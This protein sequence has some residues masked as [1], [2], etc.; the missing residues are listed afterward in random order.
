MSLY[1]K[2]QKEA[3][4]ILVRE[5]GLKNKLETPKVIKVVVNVGVSKDK[6]DQVFERVSKELA[7]VT[8]QKPRVCQAKVSVAGFSLRKGDPIGLS[9]TLRG[10][11]MYDFLE[12]LFVIVLPQVKDFRGLPIKSFDGRGNYTLGLSEQV[13]FPEIDLSKT[14]GSWGLEITIVTDAADDKRAKRLLELLGAHFEKK[15]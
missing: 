6:G 13:V 10:K 5:F 15:E 3:A 14:Q 9:T 2:Y 1:E 11:R 4:P 12:K 7:T 8:G